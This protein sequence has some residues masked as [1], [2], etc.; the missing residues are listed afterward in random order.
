MVVVG[1]VP[2]FLVDAAGIITAFVAIFAGLGVLSRF[3]P[4]RWLWHQMIAEPVADWWKALF[5][6]GAATWHQVNV[7]PQHDALRDNQ[8]RTGAWV[9][10]LAE[11]Q[12][13]P[14]EGV[15]PRT[16]LARNK[17]NGRRSA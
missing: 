9:E 5:A 8:D 11:R 6:E 13:I 12:G 7:Q 10:V 3:K 2:S 16:L 1:Q 14:T 17:Q 4:F 15:D